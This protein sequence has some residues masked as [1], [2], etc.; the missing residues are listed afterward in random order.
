MSQTP[1]TIFESDDLAGPETEGYEVS[2]A[3]SPTGAMTHVA[4]FD[5]ER[6]EMVEAPVEVAVAMAQAIL[7]TVRD[8]TASVH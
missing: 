2:V 1:L 7:A 4:F 6:Q 8:P 3:I 5:H